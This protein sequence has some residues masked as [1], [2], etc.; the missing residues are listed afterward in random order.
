MM[1]KVGDYVM[2]CGY[3]YN[4]EIGIIT[5]LTKYKVAIKWIKRKYPNGIIGLDSEHNIEALGRH[6]K[7]ISK[8][9][10]MVEML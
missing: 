5:H 10:A 1:V 9:K 7:V 6:Y 8:D 2:D 3:V 4:G